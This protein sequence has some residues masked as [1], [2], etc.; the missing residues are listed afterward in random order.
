MTSTTDALWTIQ[1]VFQKHEDGCGI[2]CVAMLAGV[3]YEEAC[4]AIFDDYQGDATSQDDLRWALMGFGFSV[5]K[6]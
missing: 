4:L 5:P 1:R 2:A 6:A 3:S